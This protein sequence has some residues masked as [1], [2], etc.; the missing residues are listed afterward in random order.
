MT[1]EHIH[2]ALTLLPADLIAEANR[3]RSGKPK[4][5]VWKRY[6]AMAA[7]F[8][9]VLC[10]GW[11]CMR[12][13]GPKG[14]ADSVKEVPME[15]AAMQAPESSN[16]VATAKGAQAPAAYNGEKATPESTE[17]EMTALPTEAAE[18]SGA[19]LQA[20]STSGSA[21]ALHPG[22]T[23]VQCMEALPGASTTA[24]FSSSPHPQLFQSRTDLE[25]YRDKDIQPFD[26]EPVMD[27]CEG[28]DNAW[29]ETHDLLLIS[30]CSVPASQIPEITA[31]YPEDG[32]WYVCI[33][34][35]PDRTEAERKDWQL[36]LTIE[37]G[38]IASEDDITL[39][40]E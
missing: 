1:A 40:F 27:A 32:Q 23:L 9:L 18:N 6:A 14:A 15:A 28:Y 20:D 19:H 33:A 34:S 10:S 12:L 8:V 4:V 35:D 36:L 24:C 29:F 7:C 37:K 21:A 38:L 17:E 25:V 31:F 2:D 11:F 39:I 5:I 26:P 13:F 22:I 16:S 30:V 3:I